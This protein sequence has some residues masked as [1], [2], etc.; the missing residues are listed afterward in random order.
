MPRPIHFEIPAD[1]PSRAQRFYTDVFGWQFRSW[2]D[3]GMEY[4]L[5]TTGEGEPGINGG[6]NR[7]QPG[8]SGV[9]NTIGVSSLDEAVAKVTAGGGSVLMP[10]MPIPG[11]GWLAYCADT[12]G[13]AFGVMQA[14]EGAGAG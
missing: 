2:G 8:N 3:G 14:D 1:D 9:V 7:R 4:W 6:M 10:K 12:E 13:N 11:V 5:I